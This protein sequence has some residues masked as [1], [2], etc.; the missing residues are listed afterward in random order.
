L[1]ALGFSLKYSKKEKYM[2]SQHSNKKL[3]PKGRPSL[4]RREA[5]ADDPIYTRGYIIGVTRTRKPANKVSSDTDK[6]K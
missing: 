6:K 2:R 5:S 3:T 4:I 1:Y